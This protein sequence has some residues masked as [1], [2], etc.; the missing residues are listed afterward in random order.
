MP[1][2]L[3]KKKQAWAN[4]RQPDVIYGEVLTPNTGT[5][6][7]YYNA[8]RYLIESMTAESDKALRKLFTTQH[9]EEY[10][11]EDASIASQA[12]II[13]NELKR[14]FDKFFADSAPTIAKSLARSSDKASS[15]QLHMSVQKLSGGLSLPTTSLAGPLTDI[16][17][18]S[19]ADN[20]SLIKSIAQE[21]LSGV[22]SAVM[23]SITTGNGLQDLIPYLANGKGITI[24]RARF[25]ARDQTKKVFEN[26]STGRMK[27]LGLDD[28][29]WIHTGGSNHPRPEHIAMSGNIY[30]I[31]N[32][33]VI[34]SKSGIRGLPGDLPGCRCRKRLV[35]KFKDS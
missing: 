28:F 14:K 20:V 12:R 16:M 32:P 29:E 3:T 33:P 18:A 34:D 4:R 26:I 13:T 1:D 9:A 24:R 17:T 11:S 21:Y 22:Q 30:S 10:F 25:I 5:E 23:R 8:L 2:L 27:L 7:R 6:I 19:I 35:I 15:A 31:S